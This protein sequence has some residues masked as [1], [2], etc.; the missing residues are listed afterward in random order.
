MPNTVRRRFLKYSTVWTAAVLASPLAKAQAS[1]L[2]PK[3]ITDVEQ[4]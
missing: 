1:G 3:I 4:V 2:T